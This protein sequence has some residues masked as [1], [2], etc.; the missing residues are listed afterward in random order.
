MQNHEQRPGLEFRRE[1]MAQRLQETARH[2]RGIVALVAALGIV[3][4]WRGTWMLLD[5]YLFPG[6]QVLSAVVSIISGLALLLVANYGFDD[7][8]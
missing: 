5:I 8:A 2:R 6:N 1:M 3:G 4:F 7:L